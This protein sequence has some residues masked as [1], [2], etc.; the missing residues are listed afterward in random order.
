MMNEM[1]MLF[2]VHEEVV[3][4]YVV[5]CEWEVKVE[6]PRGD[7]CTVNGEWKGREVDD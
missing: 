2:C 5:V 3:T 6:R 1:F 4:G 7:L